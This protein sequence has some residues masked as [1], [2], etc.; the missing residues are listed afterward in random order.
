M[1][2]VDM[3]FRHAS[4]FSLSGQRCRRPSS[5]PLAC[6]LNVH[7]ARTQNH[8]QGQPEMEKAVR[9]HGGFGSRPHACA[10]QRL[11]LILPLCSRGAPQ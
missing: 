10:V 11:I 9:Q 2:F 7:A 1:P 6:P 8:H 5:A 3:A 4:D